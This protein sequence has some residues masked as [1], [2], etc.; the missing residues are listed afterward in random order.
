M[1]HGSHFYHGSEKS[2]FIIPKEGHDPA[3]SGAETSHGMSGQW[4]CGKAHES[5]LLAYLFFFFFFGARD[6]MLA[7]L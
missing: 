7:Y 4:L 6:R 3:L 5:C 1:D 2:A